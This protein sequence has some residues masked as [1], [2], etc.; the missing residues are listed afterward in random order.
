MDD[1]VKQSDDVERRKLH[2]AVAPIWGALISIAALLWLLVTSDPG[3][4]GPRLVLAF[5]AAVFV[6]LLSC[7]FLLI[8][9]VGYLL[10]SGN[11]RS[12]YRI[13][14]SAT[15]LSFGVVFLLGLQTLGQLRLIDVVL[16]AV[17]EVVLNFYILRRF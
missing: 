16:V 14:Y 17:F 6:L 7:F 13:L 11:Q 4:G 12:W 1:S 15:V 3:Q 9:M 2:L 8:Q 5:L 10:R